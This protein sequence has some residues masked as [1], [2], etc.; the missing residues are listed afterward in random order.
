MTGPAYGKIPLKARIT[1]SGRAIT[2]HVYVHLKGYALARVTHLDIESPKLNLMKV[3]GDF[4]GIHGIKGGIELPHLG[5]K[6]SCAKLNKVLKEGE[7]TRTWVGQ[8]EDGIFIGF[9]KAEVM[10]LERVGKSRRRP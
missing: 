9:R 3:K 1:L 2:G 10:K 8:K 4:L 6:V 7:K 5:V